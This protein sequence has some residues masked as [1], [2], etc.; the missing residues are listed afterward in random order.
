MS[1]WYLCFG[2]L[3]AEQ[4]C[5]HGRY[6]ARL[7]RGPPP[8]GWPQAGPCWCTW[9]G[10]WPSARRSSPAFSPDNVLQRPLT[11][12]QKC[13]EQASHPSLARLTLTRVNAGIFY[14]QRSVQ[15]CG[16]LN[17][18]L[19]CWPISGLYMNVFISSFFFL[20]FWTTN[21]AERKPLDSNVSLDPGPWWVKFTETF[22]Y[23]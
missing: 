8:W 11:A 21:E 6:L 13:S 17:Q 2:L 9:R 16:I 1:E 23:L 19:D 20:H 5:Y 7:G 22:P 12:G 3:R 18:F 4:T 15:N 10:Q 14:N